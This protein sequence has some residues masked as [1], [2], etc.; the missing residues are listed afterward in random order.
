ML[1]EHLFPDETALLPALLA[2]CVQALQEDLAAAAEVSC[3]LSGGSTPRALYA[4]LS[5]AALPWERI[6]PALVDERWVPVDDPASNEGMLR[7]MFRHNAQ[8]LARLQGMKTAEANALEGQASCERRYRAL[9]RPWSV[10][11]LGLGRDGHT[12]SLF[13]GA[14]GLGPAL[15]GTDLCQA[16]HAVPSEVTGT[17]TERLSLTLAA[18]CSARRL[19]LYFTGA[20]KWQV[21]RTALHCHDWATLP[22]AALLQQDRVPVHVFYHP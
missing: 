20:D 14:A 15:A 1:H 21:Y 9:P 17:H 11:L 8:V 19:V 2:F 12:A 5:Q 13:P 6:T 3:L 18:L 10:V 7:T 4:Q 16:I 22:V